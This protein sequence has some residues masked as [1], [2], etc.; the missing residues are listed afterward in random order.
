MAFE[1]LKT[2]EQEIVLR[3]MKASAAHIDDW[4]KHSRLGL[5]SEELKG[6]IAEW[7]SIDDSDENGPGFLAINN[8]L[9]EVCHGFQIAP[10]EW[11]IWFNTP[12][13][14]VES[15]YRKWVSLSVLGGIR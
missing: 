7:P 12:M 6:V 8:C 10:G 11:S 2:K 3:C 14:D 4:E 15:T 13:A 1:K 9:N 5:T